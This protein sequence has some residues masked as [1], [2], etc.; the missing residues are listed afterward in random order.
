MKLAVQMRAAADDLEREAEFSL[1]LRPDQLARIWP[2]AGE[3]GPEEWLLVQ[4]QIDALWREPDGRLALLDFK[5]D[6]VAGEE[7]IARR[8]ETYRPQILLYREAARS[9]WG[10]TEVDCWL[11]FLRSGQAVRIN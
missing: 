8:A 1:R 7:A 2:A 9:I 5:S 11:Y 10:A 6:R 3:L 4:G